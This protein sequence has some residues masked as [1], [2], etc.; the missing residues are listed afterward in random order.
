MKNIFP[1]LLI[2]IYPA[3]GKAQQK[4]VYDLVKDFGAKADGKTDCYFAFKQ[5]AKALS[6][7][8]GGT[9]NIP[10]GMYYIG[11]YKIANGPQKNNVTDIVFK[12]CTKLIIKANGSTI[13]LNG[14]FIRTNDYSIPNETYR[15]SYKTTVAPFMFKNC[16]NVLLEN[17]SID[18]GVRSMKKDAVAEG[19]CSGVIVDDA[20]DEKYSSSNINITNV[21]SS[22]FATDGFIIRS[23]GKNINI[24]NC[25]A[26]Y[27]GRQGLS[28][29]KGKSILVNNCV[30]DSTGFTG[31]YGWHA[32]GAGVDV[33]NEFGK[34][35]LQDVVI[36]NC[37]MR[38]NKGFQIVTT[39]S[40]E[41]VKIDSCFIADLTYGFGEGLNGVGMYSLNSTLCNSIIFA[42]IQVDL[43][44]QQYKGEL[45]QTF[46]N[47]IIYS[48]NRA[49]VSS[50]FAR[51]CTISNNIII[52]LPKAIVGEYFP[53]IQNYNCIFNNN[54]IM[55]HAGKMAIVSGQV[56]S[57]VQYVK[58]AKNNVWLMNG[59]EKEKKLKSSYFYTTAFNGTRS[60]GNQY[61]PDNAIIKNAKIAAFKILPDSKVAAVTAYPLFTAY[62]QSRYNKLYLKQASA[63]RNMLASSLK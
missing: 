40:S 20:D 23:S 12:N 16:S 47:N 18:G 22:Y 53:Y 42:T 56:S 5:C 39:I 30:F 15:Y 27:N 7:A 63:I 41:N 57:L 9:L 50:D 14:N 46:K 62:T 48:G 54:I 24:I 37:Q 32:P 28:I 19:E 13:L 36:K 21:T 25:T 60:F 4:K 59:Y 55:M 1:L 17:V 44:D 52:M 6:D 61:F 26:K 2:F 29:V 3:T 10:K 33:E 49:M 8:G 35:N 38:S 43:A 34:G 45:V 31:A 51:P 11:Q 58:E